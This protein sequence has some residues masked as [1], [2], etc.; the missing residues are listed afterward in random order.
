LNNT[1]PTDSVFIATAA[2]ILGLAFGS[3]LNVLIYRLPRGLSIVPASKCP[4]CDQPV[5]PWFNIPVFGWLMLRGRC[6][7]CKHPFSVRYALIELC[8]G[9]L[10]ALSVLTF[11]LTPLAA[12]YI[13]FGFLVIGLVFTDAD[14]HLLPDALTLPGFWIGLLFSFLIPVGGAG[15]LARHGAESLVSFLP[16]DFRAALISLFAALIA[17]AIGAFF[18][19]GV[20][21]AYKR[22]R[23]IEGMG[24]GDVKLMAMVGAFLGVK[25]TVL[26]LVLGSVVG[27]LAGI[28]AMFA[29]FVKRARRYS[30]SA[31]D[32]SGKAWASA[33][34]VLRHY[35]MPFGVFLGTMALVSQWFGD[36][37][38]A[39]YLNLYR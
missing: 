26:T 25:L 32:S 27:S 14:L 29:V 11:G 7:E 13:V 9:I 10:F 4:N 37:M 23:G 21:E 17:A 3:F 35:E 2:F 33:Q 16:Y 15:F 8:V 18:I 36:K 38:M 28:T 22:I 1:F 34:L 6:S 19:W 20:G 31:K 5:K 24:F 12:K 30:G 39:W